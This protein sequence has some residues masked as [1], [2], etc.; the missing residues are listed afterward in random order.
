VR[1]KVWGRDVAAP[2]QAGA[3]EE[4]ALVLAEERLALVVYR[5]RAFDPAYW[6]WRRGAHRVHRAQIRRR[7]RAQRLRRREEGA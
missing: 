5:P 1:D 7:R 4:R 3:A 6:A 2:E